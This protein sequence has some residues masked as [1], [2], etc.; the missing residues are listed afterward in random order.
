MP[1]IYFLK[2]THLTEKCLKSRKKRVNFYQLKGLACHFCHAVSVR[3]Y[4]R[5]TYHLDIHQA[6]MIFL[7]PSIFLNCNEPTFYCVPANAYETLMKK[8]E[9][10]ELN[11]LAD[12]RKNQPVI[13]IRLDDF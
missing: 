4:Y 8:P 2:I 11:N 7:K 9:D 1:S 3:N 5:P 6:I 12:S 13:K 10:F